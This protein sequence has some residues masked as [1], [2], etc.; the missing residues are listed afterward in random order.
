[1]HIRVPAIIIATRAHG[2]TAAIGRFLTEDFGV[3]AAYVAGARGRNLRPVMIPGNSVDLQLSAKS[4]SQLPFG[5]PELTESRGPWLVEPLPA[6]AIGWI[7]ALSATALPERQ[8]YPPLYSALDGLLSAI[9][10]APSARGWAG[11]L[12]GYESLVLRELGYGEAYRPQS[13]EMPEILSAMD[14]LGPVL[15]HYLLADRHGDVMAARTRLRERL[16]RMV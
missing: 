7:C 14:R 15:E 5:K 10:H 13:E 6:A 8:P 2:E 4:A 11:A 1:M 9:C 3:V 16:E 12:V